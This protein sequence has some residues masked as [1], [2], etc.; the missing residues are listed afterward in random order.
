MEG[1]MGMGMKKEGKLVGY[2]ATFAAAAADEVNSRQAKK[3]RQ[4]ITRINRSQE[5]CGAIL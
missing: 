5:E 2:L 1:G 3:A 4:Q